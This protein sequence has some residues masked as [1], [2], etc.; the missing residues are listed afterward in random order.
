MN[1]GSTTNTLTFS[2]SLTPSIEPSKSSF[3]PTAMPS[4]EPTRLPSLTA[5]PSSVSQIGVISFNFTLRL[6]VLGSPVFDSASSSAV[7]RAASFYTLSELQY[8]IVRDAV[9][10]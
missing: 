9:V 2:P 5:A 4:S 7:E 10:V 6:S 1:L 3:A 8:F